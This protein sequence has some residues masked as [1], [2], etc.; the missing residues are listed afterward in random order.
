MEQTI[1]I[2]L[3]GRNIGYGAL[4][5]RISSLWNPSMPFHLMDI[6]NGY[7]L[8]KFQSPDDYAK[9]LLQGPWMIYGQYL[10]V[11]PWTKDFSPSQA[12]PSMVLAWI[13]RPGL[14]VFLYKRRILEE[15][16]GIIGKV[17]RLDF[18]T[19]SRTRGRFA[20]M[21]VYINLDKPL[22]A[23][24]I[25]NGLHQKVEYEALP[26]I[27]FTCGKYGHIKE[28][29]AAMQPGSSSGKEQN[30][31][32]PAKVTNEG[33]GAVYGPW[34][35]VEKKNRRNYRNIN[36]SENL[37][38]QGKSGSRFDA[39][40]NIENLNLNDEIKKGTEGQAVLFGDSLKSGKF[41]EHIRKNIRGNKQV[42]GAKKNFGPENSKVCRP[43]MDDSIVPFIAAATEANGALGPDVAK[44][45]LATSCDGPS[46]SN[47][48]LDHP[49]TKSGSQ[50]D[51]LGDFSK[52]LSGHVINT[53]IDAKCSN[54][55]TSFSNSSNMNIS[56]F[57]PV[58]VGQE[59]N[60]GDVSDIKSKTDSMVPELVEI[61]VTDSISSLN[62]QRHTVVSIKGKR[63][64]QILGTVSTL[65]SDVSEVVGPDSN[66][67]CASS[68][69]LRAFREY[70][71]EHKPDIVC[72][73]ETRVSGKKANAIIDKLGF[74]FSHRIE[75]IS[76]AGSW[77]H[78]AGFYLAKRE[79][80]IDFLKKLISNEEIKKALFDMALLKAPRSDGFHAHFFQKEF[81]Q[82]RPIS[83]CSVMY[84]LVMKV[85]ASRFK[86]VFP[87]YISSEQAGFIAGRNISDNILI[88]QEVI[89]SMRSRK[90]DRNWMAI[91]LDLEKAYDRIS[92]DFIDV[93]LV[94][95]GVLEF[96]R[97]VIM[98]VISS[99]SI[100]ILW[101]RVPSQ[102]FKPARG[103]RQ[104]CPLSPYLFV[105]CMEWLGHIIR[106]EISAGKWHPIQLS[107]LEPFL[108]HLFFADDL[109]IFGKTEIDQAILLKE[110]LKSFCDFSGH[111]VNTVLVPKG[112]CDEIKKKIARQFIWGSS[113]RHSK[114]TLVGWDSICKPRSRG[115]LGLRHL[116]YQNNSFIMKIAFNLISQKDA[117]WVCVLRSKYGWKNR[118]P[119][120]IHRTNYSHLW[121]SLSKVWSL[122]RENLIWSIGDGS[123]IRSWTDAWIPEVGP[124]LPYAPVLSSH[125]LE[126]SLRDWV[127]PDGT[128][129]LDLVRLWLP[130]DIIAR[131]FSVRSA[132]W[133]LKESS[134]GPSDDAWKPVWK[135]G[136]GHSSVC[137]LCGHDSE[138][139][140]HVLRDCQMAK[141]AWMLIV[142]TERRFRSSFRWARHF[143]LFITKAKSA[144]TNHGVHHHLVD[145]WVHLFTDGAVARD[146]GNTATG[147]MIR[148]RSGNWIL[149]FTHFL[150]RCS[151]LEAEL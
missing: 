134:W 72:L 125:N 12:Y 128:W 85:I 111:K 44:S 148:D 133:T 73:L 36:S 17:V 65:Q 132:Y 118:L 102:S 145:N 104:G 97:K 76:F 69:F 121:C 64:R 144:V 53:S 5:T 79:E 119:D 50:V 83:L 22:V 90:I 14:L 60:D 122:L 146:S 56:C 113:T 75:A 27:C 46:Q 4:N 25:V 130:E 78:R 123:S 59:D 142:P 20:R 87:N 110:I 67:R 108:S 70:N 136:I 66:K 107:R 135:R 51:A 19:D 92:W 34:M 24:V 74:D 9:V 147:G 47:S 151:P 114:S 80:D 48:V 37:R 15:I 103:I 94:A 62:P 8:A 124:L 98:S 61:Q 127:L 101:N 141:E 140:L 23:Q 63:M 33:D 105:F 26:T 99:S 149:G 40:T 116:Y 13:R 32:S 109:V 84:K 16:G 55:V 58:F 93:T 68:K 45:N 42:G 95:D 143:E 41:I 30:Y 18:N 120:S 52:S 129:N 131:S 150:G 77:V 54:S 96:L 81:S 57:N 106:F 89:H 71:L 31:V 82:Y 86:Q 1:V 28:L 10:T 35:V 49:C 43:A 112:L 139:I 29:C 115:G 7:F 91:N 6:E 11:Q 39:L 3:L 117:L 21:A 137:S 88:A 138:D 100:Q 38:D 2:K 126:C